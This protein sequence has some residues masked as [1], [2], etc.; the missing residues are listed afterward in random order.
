M[1]VVASE[2]A[3][4]REDR[5]PSGGGSLP[6][7]RSPPLPS[8]PT[9]VD[10][11][12]HVVHNR[13]TNCDRSRKST[14]TARSNGTC[15]VAELCPEELPASHGIASLTRGLDVPLTRLIPNAEQIVIVRMQ[16]A[17]LA[18]SK[19]PV[20]APFQTPRRASSARGPVARGRS[21][22]VVAMAKGKQRMRR[23]GGQQNGGMQMPNVP[24]PPVDPENVEFVI[25]VRSKKLLQWM[26]LSVMKGGGPANML[27]KALDNDLGKK[28][29]GNTLVENVGQAIYKD[30]DAIERSIKGQFPM[31]KATQEFEYG[32]KI[33]DKE[34]PK[35]WY[36]AKDIQVIPPVEELGNTPVE[37]MGNF[38]Q[39]LGKNL[40]L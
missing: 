23:G 3:S 4:E 11:H 20:A 27:V 32:F 34:N 10:H 7:V 31:F 12:H 16:S 39:D 25:F 1:V 21:P 30:K 28:M 13:I 14:Q 29:Y 15:R 8:P 37:K 36:L 33:R 22:Q 5:G 2:R 9:T 6:L 18:V 24:V 35:D 17:S 38:F 26:P 40:G 19:A